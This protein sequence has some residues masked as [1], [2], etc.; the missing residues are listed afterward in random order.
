MCARVQDVCRGTGTCVARMLHRWLLGRRRRVATTGCLATPSRLS[1]STHT[2]R[3][4]SVES[5]TQLLAAVFTVEVLDPDWPRSVLVR[6][7]LASDHT[8]HTGRLIRR[9][10]R[11]QAPGDIR[12]PIDLA[13]L[14][15]SPTKRDYFTVQRMRAERAFTNACVKP[16]ARRPVDSRARPR[17][18]V[19]VCRHDH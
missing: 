5:Q 2:Q 9:E 12:T 17:E 4:A 1:G 7:C 8:L 10:L 6:V 18:I 19:V 3:V 16:S 15:L 14:G 13:G 11:P